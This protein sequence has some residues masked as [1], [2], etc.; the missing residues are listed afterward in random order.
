MPGGGGVG[1]SGKGNR[2]QWGREEGK[3]FKVKGERGKRREEGG[4]IRVA[5][6]SPPPDFRGGVIFFPSGRAVVPGRN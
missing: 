1:D 6:A 3:R 2:E 5:A 4:K